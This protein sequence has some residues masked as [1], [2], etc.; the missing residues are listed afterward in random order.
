VKWL[1]A[2]KCDL[3][4][5]EI[6]FANPHIDL[7]DFRNLSEWF[8]NINYLHLRHG[9]FSREIISLLNSRDNPKIL[10]KPRNLVFVESEVPRIETFRV[11]HSRASENPDLPDIELL[12]GIHIVYIP[13]VDEERST[14][15]RRA[16][17]LKDECRNV[18]PKLRVGWSK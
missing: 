9:E 15:D 10:P 13:Y 14:L 1:G 4:D 2:S 3:R 7:D 5:L 18:Y 8:P 17:L 16:D 12:E 6:G 11:V